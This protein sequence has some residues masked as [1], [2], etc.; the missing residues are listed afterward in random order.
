MFISGSLRVSG[1]SENRVL[2][3]KFTFFFCKLVSELHWS[4]IITP[5]HLEKN[6]LYSILAI[7]EKQ[8][9]LLGQRIHCFHTIRP[10]SYCCNWPHSWYTK[11]RHGN[12]EHHWGLDLN[13]TRRKN[14]CTLGYSSDRQMLYFPFH[15]APVTLYQLLYIILNEPEVTLDLF[16]NFVR[17]KFYDSTLSRKK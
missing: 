10:I 14:I 6:I 1:P 9:I 3:F 12:S 11:T 2:Q 16:Y 7:F 8:W 5:V 4:T 13:I 15:L 17:M